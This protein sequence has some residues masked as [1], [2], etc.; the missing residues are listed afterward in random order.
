[1]VGGTGDA[2]KTLLEAGHRLP[3]GRGLVRR[4]A[5]LN[6]PVL[7]SDVSASED[8]LPN[9]L[10]PDTRAELSVP[11]SLGERVLGVIDIQEDEVGGLDEQ[12]AELIQAIASQVAIGLQN[13]RSYGATQQEARREAMI[14][15]ISQ[16][17]QRTTTIESALQ[18]AVRELGRVLGA[19]KTRVELHAP[20]EGDGVEVVR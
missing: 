8:W 11:I 12:D 18:V 20:A 4:A 7:V 6:A 9:P 17:I 10:L 16:E 13:A 2:G 3:Q 14:N 1:M 15:T 5:E 19:R